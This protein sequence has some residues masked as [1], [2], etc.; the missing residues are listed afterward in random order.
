MDGEGARCVG[1]C[2][3][4]VGCNRDWNRLSNGRRE[5]VGENLESKALLAREDAMEPYE[6]PEVS[7]YGLSL[8]TDYPLVLK[9][10][11]QV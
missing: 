1:D 3:G 10:Y 2:M 4:D 6:T 11:R 5:G 8:W 7:Y 9:G